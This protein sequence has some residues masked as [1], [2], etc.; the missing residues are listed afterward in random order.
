MKKRYSLLFV[1]PVV[2]TILL[3][4]CGGGGGGGSTPAPNLISLK[5][6]TIRTMQA[7]D[8]WNLSG[9]GTY[10]SGGSTVNISASGSETILS[11]TKQSPVT[12]IN[13]LDSFLTLSLSG[14]SG[15][16]ASLSFHGYEFQDSTGTIYECGDNDG[17]GDIWVSAASGG[18]FVSS[19]SPMAPNQSYGSSVTYTDGSTA[20]ITEHIIGTEN[21]NTNAGYY[22]AYKILENAT[23]T[24]TDGTSSVE[25]NI[26]WFV[27][28]LGTVKET[29]NVTYY[30]GSTITGNLTLTIALTSTSVAY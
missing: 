6:S 23:F 27:P 5:T 30:T 25:S 10:S 3:L 13:C 1:I 29:L 28:G 15:I 19:Q 17:S 16:P 22:E 24:Y 12:S 7:G 21:V 11:S 8:T 26:V 9:T 2:L 14:P 18:Y 4:G 20:T